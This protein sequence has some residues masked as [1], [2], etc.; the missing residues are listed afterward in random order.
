MHLAELK[1]SSPPRTIEFDHGWLKIEDIVDIAEGSARVAL[2]EAA[3]FHSGIKRGADFLDRLLSQDG[4]IYGV[5]TGY[6]DS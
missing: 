1:T 5:T 3:A 6:G 4:T 2:S